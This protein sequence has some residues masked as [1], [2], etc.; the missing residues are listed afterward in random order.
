[1][2]VT[3]RKFALWG[4]VLV[5]AAVLASCAAFTRPR[6]VHL[7][8]AS[9]EPVRRA[10]VA[11]YYDSAIFNFVDSLSRYYPGRLIRA[12]DEGR[13]EI[14]GRWGIKSPLDGTPVA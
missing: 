14:P 3:P 9:G 1:M 8:S 7:R 2:R 10:F 5:V 11:Y 13:A 4:T 6:T 12:D